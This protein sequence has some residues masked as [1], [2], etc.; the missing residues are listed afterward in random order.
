MVFPEAF[1]GGYPK[2]LGFGAR[3]GSRT[4]E[5]REEF[6]RY[7]DAAIEVPDPA[8]ELIGDVALPADCVTR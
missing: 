4:P 2:G 5:G 1:V 3:M 8:T 7:F 6:R